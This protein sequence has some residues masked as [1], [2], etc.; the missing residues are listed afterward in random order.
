MNSSISRAG[1]DRAFVRAA[2][3]AALACVGTLPVAP[4]QAA[5]QQ[6]PEVRIGQAVTGILSASDPVF[7]REGPFRV[8]RLTARAGQ[9]L[10]LT[11]RSDD[12]DALLTVM[13]PVGGITEWLAADDDGGGGTDARLRWRSPADGTYLL[14]A[15]SLERD[16]SGGFTLA[17]D[18][19]APARAATPQAMAVGETRRGT[20]TDASA[21]LV[22]DEADV[23]YDLYTFDAQAG[24]HFVVTM[25]SEDFDAFLAV[26]P[27]D[28]AD[29]TVMATDDDGGGGTNARLRFAIPADGRYGIQARPL[30]SDAVGSYTITLRAVEPLPP[31]PVTAGIAV[32]GDLEAGDVHEWLYQGTAG[33]TLRI[34]M[35]SDLFDTTLSIGT[36]MAGSFRQIAENDDEDEGS[37]N[38]FIE[39]TLPLTA[40]YVI[41]AA[42]F[43]AGES[44]SYALLVE[45]RRE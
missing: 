36:S 16:G 2:V 39:L 13:R 5:A 3:L 20:L 37:T 42:A 18:E 43:S 29:I 28:G 1:R 31:R 44:G 9:R 11:L 8:Y 17:V 45:S 27:L 10:V 19:A 23:F 6:Q 4:A 33:E 14:V 21:L 32:N 7:T 40:E 35:G 38:S 22:D 41:R 15:Q 24:Q 26:G 30:G 12:F 25:Q 34:R